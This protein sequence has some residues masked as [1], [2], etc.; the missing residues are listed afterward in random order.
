MVKLG[1]DPDAVRE[2][3][4]RMDGQAGSLGDVSTSIDRLVS[5]LCAVWQGKDASDFHGWWVNQHRP[6]LAAVQK[7]IAGLATSARNNAHEQELASGAAS[8]NSLAGPAPVLGHSIQP[9]PTHLTPTSGL[10]A[11]DFHGGKAEFLAAWKQ[12]P[13]GYDQWGFGYQASNGS[14]GGDCTSFVAWRLNELAK[15]A[16]NNDW[17][18]SNNAISGASGPVHL[19]DAQDWGANAAVAGFPPDSVPKVGSVAWFGSP[20]D[21]VAVVK[22]IGTDGTIVVEQSNYSSYPGQ[23]PTYDVT[24]IHPND[25]YR[26]SGY[27][28]FLPGT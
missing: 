24:T 6:A 11:S 1:L 3:A 22:A 5:Q 7:S 21:H 4:G 27:I 23:Y 9:S 16:G 15:A 14:S 25:S 8:G 19:G 13:S 17:S 18:F 26:P 12:E 28:H 20:H 10:S 2:I